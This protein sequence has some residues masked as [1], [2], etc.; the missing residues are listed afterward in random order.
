MDS[1]RL[2]ASFGRRRFTIANKR[3]ESHFGNASV[4][5]VQSI[6]PAGLKFKSVDSLEDARR[7]L[8]TN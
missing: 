5:S 1:E 3:P 4:A 7:W 2:D 8:V 6:I